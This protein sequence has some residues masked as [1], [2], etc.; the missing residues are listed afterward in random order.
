VLTIYT[1]NVM[2][3]ESRA[4]GRRASQLS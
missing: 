3:S 2:L 4:T 1:V